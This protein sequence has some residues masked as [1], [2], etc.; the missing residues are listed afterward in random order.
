M[1]SSRYSGIFAILNVSNGKVY[2]GQSSNIEQRLGE[3][4]KLLGKGRHENT[5]LQKAFTK[6]G[7]GSFA[8][9]IVCLCQS[10]ELDKQENT[11][12]E[13]MGSWKRSRGYNVERF[14]RGM[15]PRSK[16]AIKSMS[17]AATGRVFTADHRKKLSE[18]LKG[19]P[20]SF[21]SEE[22]KKK[23][24]E[25][26]GERS[27][28]KGSHWVHNPITLENFKIRP[29]EADPEGTVRGRFISEEQRKKMLKGP[30]E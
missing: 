27:S 23:L 2:I 15:G 12:I 28:Q 14:A 19:K 29:G 24:S 11:W 1:G 18:S 25:Y 22:H 21:R 4:R 6:Y 30:R 9:G 16:E 26:R 7:V 10:S 17:L 5:H 20:K 8:F 13:K 3:H